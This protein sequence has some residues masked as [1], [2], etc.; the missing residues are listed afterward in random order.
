MQPFVY[1]SFPGRVVFGAGRLAELPD[2]VARLGARRAI[3]LC[4]PEQRELAEAVARQLG[5]RAAGV[6]DRATMHVPIEVARAARE[7]AAGRGADC[8]VAVGGGSTV[9]LGKAI[10]LTSELPI[11]AVPTTFAGSEMTAI[12]GLTE[13][14]VKKTGRDARV[15]PRAVIYD[16]R[17]LASLPARI[18]GPSGI[19][20]V[21]HCVEA[22][23]AVDANPIVSLIA[24]EGIRALAA[25]LPRLVQ[26]ARPDGRVADDEEALSD[27]LYGAWLA[28]TALNGASM[29]IHHKLAHTLGG[30]FDLPH[31]DTHAV[32][33]PH[34]AAYVE[35]AAPEAMVRVRRAL[36]AL[37]ERAGGAAQGLALLARAVG[38]PAALR[39]LGMPESGIDRAADLAVQNPYWN[40][41]P[42]ERDAVR[43]LIE[44]AWH[45]R[46]PG[47]G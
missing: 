2:E 40:P 35:P 11:V 42:I 20:A 13:A 32:L 38:A 27:A 19:N 24:E 8:C 16:P 37:G 26:G 3:V 10:A 39:D 6:Y 34:A 21:A 15:L 43:A 31:A 44:N 30:T 47:G 22:L 9:G 23:Y 7:Y 46:P 14:G 29:A 12:W 4:T 41:R 17:L 28:G 45:G 36:G 18:A 33:L 25:G 1:T 5:D